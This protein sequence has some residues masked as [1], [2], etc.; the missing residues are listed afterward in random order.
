MRIHRLQRDLSLFKFD[1][2]I[3]FR[4]V[5]KVSETIWSPEGFVQFGIIEMSRCSSKRQHVVFGRYIRSALF[6]KTAAPEDIWCYWL[7]KVDDKRYKNGRFIF[8]NADEVG[9]EW[10]FTNSP[11]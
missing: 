8:S 6:I 5:N 9:G 11:E 4:A 3:P 2:F 1:E 7:C 10:M